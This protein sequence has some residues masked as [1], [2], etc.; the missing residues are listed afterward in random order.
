MDE[1]WSYA[2]FWTTQESVFPQIVFCFRKTEHHRAWGRIQSADTWMSPGGKFRRW[3]KVSAR[4]KFRR[5]VKVST[6]KTLCISLFS[7]SR[8]RGGS[9]VNFKS[10]SRN[11]NFLSSPVNS[12]RTTSVFENENNWCHRQSKVN[13]VTN[14]FESDYCCFCYWLQYRNFERKHLGIFWHKLCTTISLKL[15]HYCLTVLT[16]FWPPQ[17]FS[18]L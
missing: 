9:E 13:I 11:S 6:S 16:V 12:W 3:V 4:E 15:W 2:T 14:Q 7:V 17:T 10:V 18:K 5:L 8:S 1:I